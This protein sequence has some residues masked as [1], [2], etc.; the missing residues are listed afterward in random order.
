MARMEKKIKYDQKLCSF[1]DKYN[2]AFIVHA[3][4]VGSNQMM[5]IRKACGRG[6]RTRFLHHRSH[7]AANRR[8]IHDVAFDGLAARA[9]PGRRRALTWR[10]RLPL[11]L[12]Q[13]L[14]PNSEVLMG[15]NTMMKRSI[16]EY[17]AR[18]G[19]TEWNVRTPALAAFA[20]ILAN[21]DAFLYLAIAGAVGAARRQRGRHLHLGARRSTGL[22]N[23]RR[24]DK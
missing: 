12:L 19:H 18:T 1:M 5:L 14:R 24:A 15:K 6:G 23:I 2:K 11:R 10:R 21:T 17:V 7:A 20:S 8:R 4:N 16:R 22:S 9:H 3:D 13:G